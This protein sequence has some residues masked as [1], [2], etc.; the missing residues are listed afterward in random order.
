[1]TGVRLQLPSCELL[2]GAG[3]ESRPS[4]PGPAPAMQG[5]F[6]PVL[7]SCNGGARTLPCGIDFL[8]V[9]PGGRFAELITARSCCVLKDRGWVMLESFLHESAFL[10]SD[11]LRPF[12]RKPWWE[13]RSKHIFGRVTLCVSLP[14]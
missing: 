9:S 6:S 11:E 14:L 3:V 13:P 4:G 2:V 8:R 7:K 1:M 5:S 10:C 12:S